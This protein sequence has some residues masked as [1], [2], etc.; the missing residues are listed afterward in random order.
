MTQE[1]STIPRLPTHLQR[2]VESLTADKEKYRAKGRAVDV[3]RQEL[4]E[5][6]NKYE[7][8][9]IDLAQLVREA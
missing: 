6:K 2:K 1:A 8:R 7:D 4:Q 5:E 9:A 3:R